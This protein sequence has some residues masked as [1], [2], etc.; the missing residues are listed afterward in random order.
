VKAVVTARVDPVAREF[1]FGL[2]KE[3]LADYIGTLQQ[4]WRVTEQDI[5]NFIKAKR[6]K[7]LAEKLLKT[8]FVTYAGRW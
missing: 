6:L 4:T 1:L 3:Y 8:R 2:I 7:G 5:D